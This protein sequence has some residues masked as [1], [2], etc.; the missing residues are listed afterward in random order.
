VNSAARRAAKREARKQL[1]NDVLFALFLGLV[2][3]IIAALLAPI[4]WF[5]VSLAFLW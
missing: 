4:W 1:A 5:I 2:G 3:L